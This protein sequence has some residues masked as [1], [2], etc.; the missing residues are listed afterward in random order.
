MRYG[1]GEST[2]DVTDAGGPAIDG[3]DAV[4]AVAAEV[5]EEYGP[6]PGATR[7]ERMAR[8]ITLV[9]GAP[10]SSETAGSITHYPCGSHS[11]WRVGEHVGI[12]PHADYRNPDPI[13]L[14][15]ARRIA[16]ALLRAVEA[17]E[18]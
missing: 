6:D 1:R 14:E 13:P 3:V 11:V 17:A 16:A 12:A 15:D 10:L 9:A 7:I 5:L 2:F 8:W 18:G 4:L